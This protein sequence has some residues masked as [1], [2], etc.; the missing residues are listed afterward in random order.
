MWG[1]TASGG[2][3]WFKKEVDPFRFTALVRAVLKEQSISTSDEG[4]VKLA[5]SSDKTLIPKTPG[6][7]Y[8]S[9]RSNVILYGITDP[10]KISNIEAAVRRQTKGRLKHKAR[11]TFLLS[12]EIQR[13]IKVY[14]FP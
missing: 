13:V 7:V 2:V 14:R 4:P 10:R 11:L 6:K 3:L 5:A 12:Q 9:Y 8:D 1:S